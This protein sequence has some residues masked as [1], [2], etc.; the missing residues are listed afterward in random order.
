[1]SVKNGEYAINQEMLRAVMNGYAVD[2]EILCMSHEQRTAMGDK[3]QQMKKEYEE[4]VKIDEAVHISS[5][6]EESSETEPTSADESAGDKCTALMTTVPQ[7]SQE[8]MAQLSQL[9]VGLGLYGY[10]SLARQ[11]MFGLWYQSIAT[12]DVYTQAL[13][14]NWNGRSMHKTL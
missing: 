4:R 13:E 3:L 1:M 2:M 14:Q 8:F 10:K 7:L 11:T 12:K 9:Q 6:E 5:E